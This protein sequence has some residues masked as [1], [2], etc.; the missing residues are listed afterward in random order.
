MTV[1]TDLG[2]SPEEPVILKPVAIVVG[3]MGLVPRA[4]PWGALEVD[5]YV[6]ANEPGPNQAADP[7]RPN[8]PSVPPADHIL[9]STRLARFGASQGGSEIDATWRYDIVTKELRLQA[10][11]QPVPPGFYFSTGP[12]PIRFVDVPRPYHAWL[13]YERTV[14]SSGGQGSNAFGASVSISEMRTAVRGIAQIATTSDRAGPQRAPLS[15]PG[16]VWAASMEPEE[17]RALVESARF[18]VLARPKPWADGRWVACGSGG[19][20]PTFSSPTRATLSACFLTVEV[21]LVRFVD[22]RTGALL[23]EWLA[24]K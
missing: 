3:L 19:S 17:A 18:E 1:A 8:P 16:F 4:E 11:P 21:D 14:H 12:K 23:R 5:A 9:I 7:F 2:R 13:T 6:S 24:A 22:P 10:S 20:A 15:A